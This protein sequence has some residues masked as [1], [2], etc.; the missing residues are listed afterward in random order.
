MELYGNNTTGHMRHDM[1]IL[2][3]TLFVCGGLREDYGRLRLEMTI[4]SQMTCLLL[5]PENNPITH[6]CKW[7]HSMED[8]EVTKPCGIGVSSS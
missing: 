2:V 1:N 4:I 7:F 8:N 3:Y 5:I 6:V